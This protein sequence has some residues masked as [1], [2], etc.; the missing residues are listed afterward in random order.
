MNQPFVDLWESQKYVDFRT[1]VDE[2]DFSLHHLCR[3]PKW[4]NRTKKI[5]MGIYFQLAGDACGRKVSS[6]AL[7]LVDKSNGL[8]ID[9]Y[10]ERR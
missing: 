2:F 3:L 7:D 4:L 9:Y 10:D 6:A 8:T 5:V 1:R